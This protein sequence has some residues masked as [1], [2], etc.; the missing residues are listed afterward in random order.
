MDRDLVIRARGGDR[1]AF[2][3]LAAAAITRLDAVARMITRDPER[4]RAPRPR[5]I[6]RLAASPS[7]PRVCG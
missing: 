2:A 7:G 3:S 4:A 1:D 6:R 5:S